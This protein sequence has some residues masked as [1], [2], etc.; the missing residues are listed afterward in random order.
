MCCECKTYDNN[1][2]IEETGGGGEGG[3]STALVM[4]YLELQALTGMNVGDL[5]LATETSTGLTKLWYYTGNTWQVSGETIEMIANENLSIGQLVEMSG[6]DNEVIRTNS[7]GDVG[8][9]GIVQFKNVSASDYVCV[10][11]DG[12]WLVGVLGKGTPY[13][14]GNYLRPSSTL[15]LA[16]ETSSVSAEP[17]AKIAETTNVP[18]NG[19]LVKA[20]IHSQEI[21]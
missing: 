8:F 6:T 13:D 17:F 5:V 18:T 19:G 2:N 4:T 1:G 11:I 9:V 3:N 15:G 7:S 14:V 10:A 20:V 12:V 16:E 21:Y